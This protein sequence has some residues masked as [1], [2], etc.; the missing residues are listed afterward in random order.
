[1]SE[2]STPKQHGKLSIPFPFE[3]ALRAALKVKPEPEPQKPARRK[4]PRPAVKKPA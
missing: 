3:D 1:M 2:A 4:R